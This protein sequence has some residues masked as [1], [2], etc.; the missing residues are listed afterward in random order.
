MTV[1]AEEA[2]IDFGWKMAAGGMFRE[3]VA[4]TSMGAAALNG[5]NE[6]GQDFGGLEQT[7]AFGSKGALW[8][9]MA[10]ECEPGGSDGV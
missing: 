4:A 6:R 1:R 9:D 3:I 2:G 7:E 5:W 10:I 8:M